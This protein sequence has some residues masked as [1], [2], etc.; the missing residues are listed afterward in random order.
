M[1]MLYQKLKAGVLLVIVFILAFAG[2]LCVTEGFPEGGR[3]VL[4]Q[5]AGMHTKQT[6]QLHA[7]KVIDTSDSQKIKEL[8]YQ[9]ID[10]VFLYE[11]FDGEME[12]FT[13]SVED[14]ILKLKLNVNI[15]RPDSFQR[16]T[17]DYSAILLAL[18]PDL[19]Q[20]EWQYPEIQNGGVINTDILYTWPMIQKKDFVDSAICKAAKNAVAQNYGSSPSALQFL[21][22]HLTYYDKGK[23]PEK[24]KPDLK[25][26][27]KQMQKDLEA[28]P[29][30]Y[31]EAVKCDEIYVE[32]FGY[33]SQ[34]EKKDY[35]RKVWDTFYQ[36]TQKGEAASVIVGKYNSLENAAQNQTGSVYYCYICYDGIQYSYLYDFVDSNGN[37][38]FED[39]VMHGKYL[40]ES[41][42]EVSGNPMTNYYITDDAS[43]SWRDVM[44]STI[45]S[46]INESTPIEP[47]E[48]DVVVSII[49]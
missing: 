26:D 3:R 30:S 44:Y 37:H 13:F 4:M 23:L 22:E 48:A 27:K 42:L 28:L 20:I 47:V 17:G 36:K 31:D 9:V 29:V 43:V 16:L 32:F 19:K 38:D 12:P 10:K 33:S 35:N 5:R 6:E 25:I 46:G 41:D 39:G 21:I 45:Y 1:N 24:K 34:N 14:N 2:F 49:H 40:L 7:S 11:G 15:N 8:L 18:I